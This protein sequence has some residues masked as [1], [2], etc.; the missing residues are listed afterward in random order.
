MITIRDIEA[1]YDR[2]LQLGLTVPYVPPDRKYVF[3]CTTDP[4]DKPDERF[5]ISAI[6]GETQ[7]FILHYLNHKQYTIPIHI[8]KFFTMDKQD[9]IQYVEYAKATERAY[10]ELLMLDCNPTTPTQM[11]K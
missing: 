6:V 2:A 9:F 10:E 8:D 3:A 5:S 7:V 1:I 11:H 4:T